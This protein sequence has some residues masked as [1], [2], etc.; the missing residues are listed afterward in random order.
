MFA[1][2]SMKSRLFALVLGA[3]LAASP[4]FGQAA[5]GDV[6]G[7]V[8]D[9]SGGAVA[10]ASVELANVATGVKSTAKTDDMGG[11][12]FGNILVGTYNITVTAPG[13]TTTSL[14]NGAV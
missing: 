1:G 2:W 8:I 13:F 5:D 9:A 11:Y 7:T 14:R 6:V 10:N 3:A 4:V 12:R